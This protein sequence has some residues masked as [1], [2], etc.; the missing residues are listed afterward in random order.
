MK[1]GFPNFFLNHRTK[2]Y[3][4]IYAQYMLQVV[5]HWQCSQVNSAAGNFN[6]SQYFLYKLQEPAQV[7]SCLAH[8]S[9]SEE[10]S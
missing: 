3:S 1:I 10:T 7:L 6:F 8:T 4:F 2:F 5:K 9:Y